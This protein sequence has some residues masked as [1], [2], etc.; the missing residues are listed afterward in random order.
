MRIGHGY[1]VQIWWSWTYYL[2]WR[3]YSLRIRIACSFRRRCAV[4]RNLR[5]VTGAVSG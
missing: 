2:R 3:K 5:C 4:A 1:D